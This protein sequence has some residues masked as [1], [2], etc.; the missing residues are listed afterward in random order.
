MKRR[1]GNKETDMIRSIRLCLRNNAVLR[2]TVYPFVFSFMNKIGWKQFLV[3]RFGA[4]VL[5]MVQQ[6]SER[7]GI[8]CSPYFG[9]LLGVVREKMLLRHD[10]DMD[11]IIPMTTKDTVRSFLDELSRMGFHMERI[12]AANEH[13]IEISYRYRE[14]NVDF[15][16]MGEN[17]KKTRQIHIFHDR[18]EVRCHSYPLMVSMQSLE[19]KIGPVMVPGNA[20]EHLANEYGDWRTP[21]R[22][23][24]ARRGPSFR[25][26]LDS[27][28]YKVVEYRDESLFQSLLDSMT[29]HNPTIDV[30]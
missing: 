23:W 29:L 22:H 13:V 4:Q 28:V 1:N 11:F 5:Q 18:G 7:I 24:D 26:V 25:Q 3:R 20:E 8:V 16:L 21:N 14:I 12:I 27:D 6:V 30:E 9:T 15:I 2:K 10:A 17:V 19:T